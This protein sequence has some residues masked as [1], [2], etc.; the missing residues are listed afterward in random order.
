M[1]A[2]NN[3][4]LASDAD[5]IT[6]KARAHGDEDFVELDI[7]KRMT[8]VEFKAACISE[9]DHIEK[10][11]PVLKIRKLPNVLVRKTADI[12]R[13]KPDQEIELILGKL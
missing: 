4:L 12:K 3:D 5:I 9:L 6:I 10:D 8:F 13:I 2:T 7:D 1:E 11:A